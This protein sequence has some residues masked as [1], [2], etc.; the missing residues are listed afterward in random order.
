MGV[1]DSIPSLGSG[2]SFLFP[3]LD[4]S[5]SVEMGCAKMSAASGIVGEASEGGVEAWEGVEMVVVGDGMDSVRSGCW[6]GCPS[7]SS[8]V[9]TVPGSGVMV[10]TST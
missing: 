10:L 2:W 7:V 1:V 5:E 4:G 8:V 6:L 3:M 9:T